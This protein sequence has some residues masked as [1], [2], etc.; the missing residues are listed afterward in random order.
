MEEQQKPASQRQHFLPRL[1]LKGFAHRKSGKEYYVYEFRRVQGTH[2]V[3]IKNVAVSGSFY[4]D[5]EKIKT[6]QLLSVK[7]NEYAPILENLRKGQID[8]ARKLLIDEFVTHLFVRNKYIR[9]ALT[10]MGQGAFDS[11][12]KNYAQPKIPPGFRK[13][14]REKILASDE[15]RALP[16]HQRRLMGP[17]LDRN[18]DK[19]FLTGIPT[20]A[21]QF[22]KGN[23][24]IQELVKR[25]QSEVLGKLSDPPQWKEKLEPLAWSVREYSSGTFVLGDLG[26]IARFMDSDDFQAPIKGGA[27]LDSIFLPISSQHLLVGQ[28]KG[29]AEEIDPDVINIASVEL[30]RDFFVSGRNTDRERRYLLNLGKRSSLLDEKEMQRLAQESLME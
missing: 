15:F 16:R 30:S 8:P 11:I 29:K 4:G 27:G 1:L 2:E 7:E 24:D 26:P 10:Q 9:D 22:L 17:T 13:L 12:E 18:I 25:S 6:E 21:F 3:N 19:F 28:R 5:S 20:K 23:I 14:V